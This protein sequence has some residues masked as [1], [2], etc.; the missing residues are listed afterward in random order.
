M[1]YH[2][3]ITNNN[4]PRYSAKNFIASLVLSCKTNPRQLF[5]ELAFYRTI[6]HQMRSCQHCLIQITCQ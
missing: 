5:N 4:L 6:V 2:Y 3:N 1:P